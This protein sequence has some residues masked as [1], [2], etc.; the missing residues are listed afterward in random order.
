MKPRCG[1]VTVV[2]VVLLGWI[3]VPLL[4]PSASA[5]VSSVSCRSSSHRALA[6]KDNPTMAYG[7]DIIEAIAR[8]INRDLNPAARSRV[9]SSELSPSWGTPDELLLA[10]AGISA[11]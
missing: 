3:P 9:P 5:A 10:V 11:A 2:T 8:A 6:A 7:I 1:L 4:A